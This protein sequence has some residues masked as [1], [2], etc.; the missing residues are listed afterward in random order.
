[1]NNIPA[2]FAVNINSLLLL[3]NEMNEFC[4]SLL[5]PNT[6]FDYLLKDKCDSSDL[7]ILT[8]TL[9]L[10]E[11]TSYYNKLRHTVPYRRSQG[12]AYVRV[13]LC[14]CMKNE[15]RSNVIYHI[16]SAEDSTLLQIQQCQGTQLQ[17]SFIVLCRWY[18][19]L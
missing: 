2:K 5:S 6:F 12:T 16:Q 4:C 19:G 8:M 10:N 13:C 7:L 18:L 1:M 11:S 15:K 3:S 17:H 9:P 14:E